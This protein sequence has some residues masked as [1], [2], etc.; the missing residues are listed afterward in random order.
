MHALWTP[1]KKCYVYH[2]ESGSQAINNYQQ[3]TILQQN[4]TNH[5]EFKFS[6][7]KRKLIIILRSYYSCKIKDSYLGFTASFSCFRYL[8][9]I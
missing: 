1:E 8:T 3:E 4:F 9:I 2:G 6:N 7:F 5:T